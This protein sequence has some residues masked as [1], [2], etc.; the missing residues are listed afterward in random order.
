MLFLGDL[1][2]T[3][4]RQLDPSSLPSWSL[5]TLLEPEFTA[6]ADEYGLTQLHEFNGSPVY[7]ELGAS[8]HWIAT[9]SANHQSLGLVIEKNA[10]A[11]AS[12][13][14]G[15]VD[16]T[17]YLSSDGRAFFA[18]RN[19]Q[20]SRM[21]SSFYAYEFEDEL[22]ATWVWAYLN[23][24]VD[25]EVRHALTRKREGIPKP[26]LH[27][28]V[29]YVRRRPEIW[30]TRHA[31]A[32]SLIHKAGLLLTESLSGSVAQIIRL[33]QGL[34]WQLR[35]PITE[36]QSLDACLPSLGDLTEEIIPGRSLSQV[37]SQAPTSDDIP[38]LDGSWI[39]SGS[40]TKKY[41]PAPDS[42]IAEA[43]DVILPEIGEVSRARV[44]RESGLVP[45]GYFVLRF[46]SQDVASRVAAFLNSDAASSQRSRLCDEGTLFKHLKVG[47]VRNIRIDL[48]AF[49]IANKCMALVGN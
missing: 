11:V 12:F 45:A 42:V 20:N 32:R 49:D 7:P 19:N 3:S 28:N 34:R 15:A 26:G 10:A 1:S 2:V 16:R 30:E 5:D 25:R 13:E 48:E 35:P 6:L 37:K 22:D 8:G 39:L 18:P 14:P 9:A 4:L 17:L 33:Q 44:A 21:S 38:V 41:A 46:S 29:P 40:S 36:D 23:S 43:G 47:A 27:L 24:G 31:D